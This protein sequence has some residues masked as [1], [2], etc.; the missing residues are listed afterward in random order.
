MQAGVQGGLGDADGTRRGLD[1]GAFKGLHQLLEALALFAAQQVLTLHVE[2]V[3]AQFVFLHAPVAE[4]LDLTAGHAGGGEGVFLGAGG[5]FGQEHRQT[6]VIRALGVRAGQHCHDMGAGSVGDPG[7]VAGDLV[8]AIRSLH[9]PGAQAG[10]VGACVGLRE[11]G[12][13]QDLSGGEAGQPFLFLRIG[14][15]AKDQLCRD[16]RP[17]AKGTHADVA[18]RQL[19]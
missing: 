3:E 16:L 9:R 4:H 17:G 19:F 15:T 14:A 12:R 8:I 2:A 1:P 10:Q 18:A 11:D 6:T 13:W 7:L 5:L